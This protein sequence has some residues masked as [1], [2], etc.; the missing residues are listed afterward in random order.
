MYEYICNMHII[1]RTH[2]HTNQI[3]HAP[4]KNEKQKNKQNGSIRTDEAIYIRMNDFDI[5]V[6]R[7]ELIIFVCRVWARTGKSWC[8]KRAMFICEPII[9]GCCCRRQARYGYASTRIQHRA[10]RAGTRSGSGHPTNQIVSIFFLR[11]LECLRNAFVVCSLA[12]TLVVR[13]GV[14]TM[15]TYV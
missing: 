1:T 4:E 6:S 10:P 9:Y 15:Y 11:C 14:Y 13:V 7:N 3:H 8:P 5:P 2:A 12:Q